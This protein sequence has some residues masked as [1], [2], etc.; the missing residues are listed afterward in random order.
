MTRPKASFNQ[1]QISKEKM[2]PILNRFSRG[3]LCPRDNDAKPTKFT[4]SDNWRKNNLEGKKEWTKADWKTLPEDMVRNVTCCNTESLAALAKENGWLMMK[5]M[6]GDKETVIRFPKLDNE[7]VRISTDDD[8]HETLSDVGH[9]MQL[10]ACAVNLVISVITSKASDDERRAQG[11]KYL[12]QFEDDLEQIKKDIATL[13]SHAKDSPDADVKAKCMDQLAHAEKI[14][15]KLE[16]QIKKVSGDPVNRLEVNED[17]DVEI[18][19]EK[20]PFGE[21]E[22]DKRPNLPQESIQGNFNR[23][24]LVEPLSV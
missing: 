5:Y 6:V 16:E 12:K 10:R 23:F 24:K 2:Q 13:K 19:D 3:A 21:I 14:K 11:E 22:A 20:Y 4:E 9:I 8:H 7:P 1:L 15:E 17:N 18:E